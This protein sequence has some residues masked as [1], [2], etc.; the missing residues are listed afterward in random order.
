MRRAA[1]L[2][3]LSLSLQGCMPTFSHLMEHR[4]YADALCRARSA[5][6]A[7]ALVAAVERD[8]EM[9]VHLHTVREEE[10]Q[11]ALGEQG[12]VIAGKVTLVRMN[13]TSNTIPLSGFASVNLQ[14][15]KEQARNLT[16]EHSPSG[17]Q[18]AVLFALTG[19]TMP[20]ASTAVDTGA[21]ARELTWGVF[22]LGMKQL[23]FGSEKLT[24][25][26]G[27]GRSDYLLSGPRAMALF[28]G[29]NSPPGSQAFLLP[30]Q[31]AAP[32]DLHLSYSTTEHDENHHPCSLHLGYTVRLAEVGTP[33]H[34][35]T[36]QR[37]GARAPLV[38]ELGAPRSFFLTNHAG[39]WHAP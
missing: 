5:P 18:A 37:F 31:P 30:A 3:L 7:E 12:K 36:E 22:T 38:T 35:A 32:V 29:L 17:E 20:G 25:K 4:R 34:R 28:D 11:A 33:L 24:Y 16:G 19:E 1:L 14:L 23:L 10:L 8:A 6:E 27:P 2:A 39:S 26:V 13:L 21:L 9:R 15:G